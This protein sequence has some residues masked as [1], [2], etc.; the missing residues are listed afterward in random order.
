[1]SLKKVYWIAPEIGGPPE[2]SELLEE[3]TAQNGFQTRGR[4][5][6]APRTCPC[7]SAYARRLMRTVLYGGG[8]FSVRLYRLLSDLKYFQRIQGGWLIRDFIKQHLRNGNDKFKRA[9]HQEKE[10]EAEDSSD[11]EDEE[12]A[13][14]QKAEAGEKGGKAGG[15]RVA[16][17]DERSDDEDTDIITS[18]DE[19]DDVLPDQPELEMNGLQDEVDLASEAEELIDDI[20][21]AGD[22]NM[23]P[24]PKVPQSPPRLSAKVKGKG[25]VNSTSS[26]VKPNLVVPPLSP[27]ALKPRVRK[28]K[29]PEPE[30]RTP[31]TKKQFRNVRLGCGYRKPG[32]ATFRSIIPSNMEQIP[33][34]KSHSGSDECQLV[35]LPRRWDEIDQELITPEEF[36]SFVLIPHVAASL[37]SDDL[38]ISLHDAVEGTI[39][40]GE[41]LPIGQSCPICIVH[42]TP[43]VTIQYRGPNSTAR[44]AVGGEGPVNENSAIRVFWAIVVPHSEVLKNDMM[45][46]A[47][48]SVLKASR[49][50]F[51]RIELRRS[52]GWWGRGKKER[53]HLALLF[54]EI[55]CLING[56]PVS[57]TSFLR[58]RT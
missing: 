9:M 41:P 31:A 24:S 1:M 8:A 12:M 33:L 38:N 57:G 10:A 18:D 13:D 16:A 46:E 35:D 2:Q 3:L 50:V 55:A 26:P 53:V 7:G 52:E 58:S 5:V 30:D 47:G 27:P 39:V 54:H 22:E 40:S 20:A 21:D 11:L 17:R 56:I 14:S 15:S 43:D 32:S 28:R 25:K 34:S 19:M 45:A 48:I 51:E 49:R 23:P 37:I 6:G 44:A 42:W 4:V 29:V 36:A